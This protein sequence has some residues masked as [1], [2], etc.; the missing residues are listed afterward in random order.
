MTTMTKV[1]LIYVECDVPEGVTLTEY[2]RSTCAP[3]KPRGL[4]RLRALLGPRPVVA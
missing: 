3:A 2:R 1:P 4:R